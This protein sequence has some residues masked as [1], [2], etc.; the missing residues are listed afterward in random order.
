MKSVEGRQTTTGRV[1]RFQL[2]GGPPEACRWRLL[3]TN[4]VSLGLGSVA[5]PGT[6]ECVAAIRWLCENLGRTRMEFSHHNGIRW[7]WLVYAGAEPIAVSSH[8]YG[9]RIEAK[10]GYER[11]VIGVEMATALAGDG[12]IVGLP[13]RHRLDG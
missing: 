2:I 13:S 4:N 1:P 3:G 10:H 8:A 9:R 6:T 12:K 7:R 11:F 5:Y